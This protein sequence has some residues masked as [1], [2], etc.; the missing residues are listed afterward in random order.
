MILLPARL[1]SESEHQHQLKA[2]QSFE[3]ATEGSALHI[4]IKTDALH[5][6]DQWRS[7]I[8]RHT[9]RRHDFALGASFN[10]GFL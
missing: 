8:A 5:G 1:S 10:P 9:I 4:T 7:S 3:V 2:L 6:S